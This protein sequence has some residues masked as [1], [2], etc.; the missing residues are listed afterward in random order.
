MDGTKS[1]ASEFGAILQLALGDVFPI[2]FASYEAEIRERHWRLWSGA[3]DLVT[4]SCQR[5]HC[6]QRSEELR[7]SPH[8]ATF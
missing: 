7:K 8:G 5:Q 3:L 4:T 2:G 6:C 1:L